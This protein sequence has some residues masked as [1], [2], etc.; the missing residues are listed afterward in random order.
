MTLETPKL[1]VRPHIV[2]VSLLTASNKTSVAAPQGERRRLGKYAR[3]T[4]SDDHRKHWK[5]IELQIGNNLWD[6]RSELTWPPM[7]SS[8]DVSNTPLF[9]N[10]D[11]V[12][13]KT[14]TTLKP[15]VIAVELLDYQR[16]FLPPVHVRLGDGIVTSGMG[17]INFYHSKTQPV[18]G[19]TWSIASWCGWRAEP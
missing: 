1:R 19:E 2:S 9:H 18:T 17:F 12:W 10:P 7:C 4:P 8:M 6:C 16:W 13:K 11:W 5:L 15:D 14:G 3:E